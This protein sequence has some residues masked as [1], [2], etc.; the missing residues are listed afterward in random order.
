MQCPPTGVRVGRLRVH[1]QPDPAAR[2][3]AA[4]DEPVQPAD[5]RRLQH[6]L[7]HRPPLLHADPL[8]R[9]PAGQDL[10]AHGGGG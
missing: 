5:L 4:P 3:R 7:H 9:V 1:H 6:V 8:R 2:V 10:R